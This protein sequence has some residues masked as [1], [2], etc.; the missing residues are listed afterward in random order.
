MLSIR[1]P[2]PNDPRHPPFPAP[3]PRPGGTTDPGPHLTR[4][5]G[6]V[7]LY[8]H[9][10]GYYAIPRPATLQAIAQELG[11]T[12]TSLSLLLRR[13]EKKIVD[14]FVESHR[15]TAPKP[16]NGQGHRGRTHGR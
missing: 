1:K 4:R 13:A 15:P 6:D 14:S 11:I 3:E 8:C 2:E 12:A 16:G 9:A 7:L 5:Q 10:R